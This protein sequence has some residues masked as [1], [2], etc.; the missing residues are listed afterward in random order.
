MSPIFG[1]GTVPN[2]I[3]RTGPRID[4]TSKVGIR[5]KTSV[6]PKKKLKP[7]YSSKKGQNPENINDK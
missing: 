2:V 3:I 4:I 7:L 6:R 1:L 5:D